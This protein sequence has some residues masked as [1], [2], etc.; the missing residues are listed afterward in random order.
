MLATTTLQNRPEN[1]RKTVLDYCYHCDNQINILDGK[2]PG[3]T[4]DCIVETVTKVERNIYEDF[5]SVLNLPP[6]GWSSIHLTAFFLASC[7]LLSIATTVDPEVAL[8]YLLLPGENTV[9]D[10]Q[11][12]RNEVD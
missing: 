8:E 6:I 3:I 12:L 10:I 5:Q 11:E 4:E 9:N 2:G 7:L 1:R